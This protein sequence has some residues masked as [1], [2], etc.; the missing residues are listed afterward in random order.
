METELAGLKSRRDSVLG[1][2]DPQDDILQRVI[3]KYKN[4]KRLYFDSQK[5]IGEL[6]QEIEELKRNE[7]AADGKDKIIEKWREEYEKLEKQVRSQDEAEATITL[8]KDKYETLAEQHDTLQENSTRTTD[9]LRSEIG[10]LARELDAA[11]DGLG[12]HEAELEAT[13]SILANTQQLLD[14]TEHRLAGVQQLV[15]E[16]EDRLANSRAAANATEA[17]LQQELEQQVR[18]LEAVE[19]ER[20]KVFD[21]LKRLSDLGQDAT[22]FL[23]ENNPDRQGLGLR[24]GE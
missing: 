23:D 13:R 6:K 11:K 24:E 2:T 19:Q 7:N 20:G 8:W 12:S 10:R 22:K 17:T 18:Q 15:D 1:H 14:E 4:V 5:D 16:R 3:S 9:E 21:F